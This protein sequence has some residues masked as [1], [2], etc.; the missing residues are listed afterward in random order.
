ML[1]RSPLSP[2]PQMCTRL[3]STRT[4]T[5]EVVG[6]AKTGRITYETPT[7]LPRRPARRRTRLR[8][9]YLVTFE[10]G[11]GRLRLHLSPEQWILGQHHL[12]D[13]RRRRRY[14]NQHFIVF[15]YD[16]QG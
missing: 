9:A 8:A 2:I 14:L 10:T 5:Y 6:G 11:A 1:N 12:S 7:A 16:H 4:L 3:P 13:Q 15:L